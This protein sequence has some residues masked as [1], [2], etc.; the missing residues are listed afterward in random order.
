MR[1]QRIIIV[2][3]VLLLLIS[4]SAASESTYGFGVGVQHGIKIYMPI[5]RG[6]LLVEPTVF[7]FD[8]NDKSSNASTTSSFDYR[9]V[10]IGLG[11]FVRKPLLNN[12]RIYYGAR[13]GYIDRE[14]SDHVSGS[15]Y[16]E[17]EDGYFVAPT[18]GAQYFLA[19]NFSVGLEAAVRYEK[20]E[21][22]DV[23]PSSPASDIKNSG[24]NTDAEIIVRYQFD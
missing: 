20:T 11:M 13:L 5:E 2:L 16:K 15:L 14:R 23:G 8:R 21:G 3:A 9:D 24:Y 18:I 10:E 12:A 1:F 4:Q 6:G 22:T 19:G 7:V 17:N